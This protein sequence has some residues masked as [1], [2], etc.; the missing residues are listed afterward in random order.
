MKNSNN[1]NVYPQGVHQAQSAVRVNI[2]TTAEGDDSDE[3]NDDG[4]DT[5]PVALGPGH[6]KRQMSDTRGL[7]PAPPRAQST[8]PI[9]SLPYALR[10]IVPWEWESDESKGHP[11]S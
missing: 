1:L 4:S 3:S 2:R 8:V 6:H 11:S 10:R 9:R 7:S 5:G